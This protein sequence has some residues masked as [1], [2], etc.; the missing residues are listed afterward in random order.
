MNLINPVE[1]NNKLIFNGNNTQIKVKSLRV[2]Y[3]N[4]IQLDNISKSNYNVYKL[5]LLYS[6]KNGIEINNSCINFQKILVKNKRFIQKYVF[7]YIFFSKIFSI[8]Q[9]FLYLQLFC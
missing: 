3:V 5:L 7:H 8:L 1:Q 6:G 2:N 4:T 9:H